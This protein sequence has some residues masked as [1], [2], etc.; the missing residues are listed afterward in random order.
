MGEGI[1]CSYGGEGLEGVTTPTP[2]KISIIQQE[3]VSI[4]V[5]CFVFFLTKFNQQGIHF[6]F[7]ESIKSRLSF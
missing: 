7:S 2:Q 6:M 1:N 3:L 5:F 4:V